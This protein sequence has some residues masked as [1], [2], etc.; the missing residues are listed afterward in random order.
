MREVYTK[1][2]TIGH[3]FLWAGLATALMKAGLQAKHMFLKVA[4]T[5]VVF[6]FSHQAASW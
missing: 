1:G 3:V 2:D 4:V 5:C 6:G